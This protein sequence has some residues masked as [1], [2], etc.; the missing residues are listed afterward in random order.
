MLLTEITKSKKKTFMEQIKL[1]RLIKK[2]I[3]REEDDDHLSNEERQII[4]NGF[5]E[6]NPSI[7]LPED[8]DEAFVEI[9]F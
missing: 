6:L 7:E 2:A 8:L 1:D 4:V 3:K 9:I 5:K